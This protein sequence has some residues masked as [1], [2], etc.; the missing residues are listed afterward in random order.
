[1]NYWTQI[2]RMSL[3]KVRSKKNLI[4]VLPNSIFVQHPGGLLRVSFSHY[5][6]HNHGIGQTWSNHAIRQI[7]ESQRPSHLTEYEWMESDDG[8][9]L[10]ISMIVSTIATK[11]TTVSSSSTSWATSTR[12][13]LAVISFH[14]PHK[15]PES[16]TVKRSG[17]S[18]LLA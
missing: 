14:P 3:S 1:M 8:T 16:Q 7:R 10:H 18:R 2:S 5:G 4:E 13:K 12:S 6:Q 11:T 15:R 9:K 17:C